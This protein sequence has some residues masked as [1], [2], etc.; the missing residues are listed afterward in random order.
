MAMMATML[1]PVLA[2]LARTS[3]GITM[4]MLHRNT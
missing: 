2:L 4:V 1:A 3:F